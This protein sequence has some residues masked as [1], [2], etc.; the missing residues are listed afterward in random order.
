MKAL[1][2][3]LPAQYQSWIANELARMCRQLTDL[4]DWGTDRGVTGTLVLTLREVPE[5]RKEA[6]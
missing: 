4:P 3:Y 2:I 5:A 1:E 6:A